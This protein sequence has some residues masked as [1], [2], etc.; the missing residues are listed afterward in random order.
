MEK[1]Q[2]SPCMICGQNQENGIFILSGFLCDDCEMEMVETD[3]Q[4]ERYRYF[5]Q[6]MKSQLLCFFRSNPLV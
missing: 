1:K 2:V 6:Q 5:V 4:D 3:A